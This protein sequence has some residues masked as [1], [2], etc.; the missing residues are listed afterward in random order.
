MSS[1]G[2]PAGTEVSTGREHQSRAFL[3]AGECDQSYSREA[4]T[5]VSARATLSRSETEGVRRPRASGGLVVVLVV[6]RHAHGGESEL[7]QPRVVTG[8][9]RPGR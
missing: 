5:R 6:Q 9:S 7:M 4:T 8:P 2:R 1:A 3:I